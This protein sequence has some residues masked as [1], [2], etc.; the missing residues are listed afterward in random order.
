MGILPLHRLV[1]RKEVASGVES[2]FCTV[3]DGDAGGIAVSLALAS[4]S[5]ATNKNMLR[6]HVSTADL[7]VS[8]RSMIA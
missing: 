1:G 3:A 7:P 5:E 2:T 8:Y 6:V 4:S